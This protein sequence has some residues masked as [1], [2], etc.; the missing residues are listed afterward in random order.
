MSVSHNGHNTWRLHIRQDSRDACTVLPKCFR[1]FHFYDSVVLFCFNRKFLV[2]FTKGLGHETEF[3]YKFF[4][5]LNKNQLD[6]WTQKKSLNPNHW[7]LP[8][9]NPNKTIRT[10]PNRRTLTKPLKPNQTTEP[11]TNRWTL[12]KPLNPHQTVGPS[13][14]RCALTKPLSANQIVAWIGAQTKLLSEKLES[15]P[16]HGPESGMCSV[17][18]QA[19][20]CVRS[21][22]S[23]WSARLG[24]L[25]WVTDQ[26]PNQI[27]PSPLKLTLWRISLN[28]LFILCPCITLAPVRHCMWKK[29]SKPLEP[30]M[31][32]LSL[33]INQSCSNGLRV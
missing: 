7:T 19:T 27:F 29:S 9:L 30:K 28:I 6:L 15:K 13:T 32:L 26:L 10:S 24:S 33:E 14:N 2:S 16:N 8:T 1:F 4:C 18:T 17:T 3:K 12:T 5:I 20:T 25:R 21:T 31:R 23:P 11:S 22:R